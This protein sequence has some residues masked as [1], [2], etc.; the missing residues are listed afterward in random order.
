MRLVPI[1]I[2]AAAVTSA[3]DAAI[4][5][6]AACPIGWRTV[7]G[8]VA[9]ASLAI[10]WRHLGRASGGDYMR[11]ASAWSA[12]AAG[13]TV[14]IAVVLRTSATPMRWVGFA[15]IVSGTILQACG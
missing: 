14:A 11:A 5:T 15:L 6:E 13:L 3:A 7:A 9:Y 12:C 4:F 8:A 10:V 1:A 2:L